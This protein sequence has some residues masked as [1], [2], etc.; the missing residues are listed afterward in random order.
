V[1]VNS[2]DRELMFTRSV[3]KEAAAAESYAPAY[4][5]MVLER[6]K[7]DKKIQQH[8]RSFTNSASPL[9]L[10]LVLCTS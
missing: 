1:D 6:D 9:M 10:K 7:T 4:E 8:E 3:R 2:P 5:V